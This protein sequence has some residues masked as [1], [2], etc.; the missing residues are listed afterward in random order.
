MFYYIYELKLLCLIFSLYVLLLSAKPCC[1]E[2]ICQGKKGVEK[3]LACKN[4][5]DEKECKGC[6]PFFSC[7]S[8]T[9][10]IVAKNI[11]YTFALIFENSVK[12]HI[13]Y[14]QPCL[15]EPLLAIWQPPKI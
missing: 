12:R 6:S 2:D 13:T 14:L 5:S 9:G 15:Q 1:S 11:A 8:C 7:G 4:S 10:F 3:E